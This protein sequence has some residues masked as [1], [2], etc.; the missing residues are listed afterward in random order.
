[1]P[2]QYYANNSDIAGGSTLGAVATARVGVECADIG[3]AQLAMHSAYESAGSAD[4][5]YMIRA[6]QVF[7]ESAIERLSDTR[8]RVL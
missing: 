5:A 8:C 4:T 2:Y 1:V 6:C 3:L 7:Y